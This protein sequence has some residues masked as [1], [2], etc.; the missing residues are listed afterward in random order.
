MATEED[1]VL[2]QP[3]NNLNL[4]MQASAASLANSKGRRGTIT[5]NQKSQNALIGSIQHTGRIYG[6]QVSQPSEYEKKDPSIKIE[7]DPNTNE[8]V[9]HKVETS[10]KM[11]PIC[12]PG[13]DKFQ[14]ILK[15]KKN[16]KAKSVEQMSTDE[17]KA[18]MAYLE[19]QVKFLKKLKGFE[20][21]N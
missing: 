6:S 7:Y 20:Q 10:I 19:A 3:Q 14:N 9:T 18:K 5:K 13:P 17:I 12:L 11:E 8:C 15:R 16:K 2:R 21:T 4:H 1:L